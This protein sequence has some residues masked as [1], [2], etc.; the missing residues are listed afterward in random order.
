MSNRNTAGYAAG[1]EKRLSTRRNTAGVVS[2]RRQSNKKDSQQQ[3]QQPPQ[4]RVST[5]TRR[6]STPPPNVG[7]LSNVFQGKQKIESKV[8]AV[9]KNV[10]QIDSLGQS[11]DSKAE[12]IFLSGNVLRNLSGIERF[13]NLRVLSVGSNYLSTFES[14]EPLFNL[15]KLEVLSLI[16]NPVTQLP[17]Y[18]C[19]VILNCKHL[20]TLDNKEISQRER[21]IAVKVSTEESLQLKQMYINHSFII[22]SS[23]AS[24]TILLMASLPGWDVP[25]EVSPLMF[26]RA[27][28]ESWIAYNSFKSITNQLQRAV[29]RARL[30][31]MGASGSD[32]D[33]DSIVGWKSAYNSVSETQQGNIQ[34][35]FNKMVS[36]L[37]KVYGCTVST[38]NPLQIFSQHVETLLSKQQVGLLLPDVLALPAT[39]STALPPQQ[40]DPGTP[41][42]MIDNLKE[43]LT[44]RNEEAEK[45]H[46]RRMELSR[47][48]LPDPHCHRHGSRSG[49]V[50]PSDSLFADHQESVKRPIHRDHQLVGN[51]SDPSQHQRTE[52][53]T[54]E[55]FREELEKFKQDQEAAKHPHEEIER[56][57][58]L[59][60]AARGEL[61]M[62][63]INKALRN[64]LNNYQEALKRSSEKYRAKV[65]QFKTNES[66]LLQKLRSAEEAY[67]A[68]VAELDSAKSEVSYWKV[69][70]AEYQSELKN[71]KEN[72][73]PEPTNDV[74]W[75]QQAEEYFNELQ[76]LKLNQTATSVSSNQQPVTSDALLWKQRSE[77]LEVENKRLTLLQNAPGKIA[78][79][80][81]NWK[82]QCMEFKQENAQLKHQ[83][84][85]QQIKIVP[86]R[87]ANLTLLKEENEQLKYQIESLRQE[88]ESDLIDRTANK[89]LIQSLRSDCELWKGKASE[90]LDVIEKLRSAVELG[91]SVIADKL[92]G[93]VS[94]WKSKCD[95]QS[96]ELHILSQHLQDLQD[97]ISEDSEHSPAADF[98]IKKRNFAQFKLGI[99]AASQKR[100]A[101]DILQ[102]VQAKV[103]VS[104]ALKEWNRI[105]K[106]DSFTQF[107]S[108]MHCHHL[109]NRYYRKLLRAARSRT[110]STKVNKLAS[111][112]DTWMSSKERDDSSQQSTPTVRQKKVIP[113]Q[114][115][116]SDGELINQCSATTEDLQHPITVVPQ[117]MNKTKLQYLKGRYQRTISKKKEISCDHF[118]QDE[119]T[120]ETVGT[121]VLTRDEMKST[122]KSYSDWLKQ[123]HISTVKRQQQQQHDFRHQQLS[124]AMA[125]WRRQ[126]VIE[127]QNR[128]STT[129]SNQII[130]NKT[131]SLSRMAFSK[132]TSALKKR[133]L[134]SHLEE[135]FTSNRRSQLVKTHFG[136]WKSSCLSKLV[137]YKS[138]KQIIS[139]EVC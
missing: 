112:W 22:K 102:S 19:R 38:Q 1:H 109:V 122:E 10:S 96:H 95:D 52:Q 71:I 137:Q 138:E 73:S 35:E 59:L 106:V 54:T 11:Q 68:T 9:E 25:S 70:S 27:S 94:F 24:S 7:K 136:N 30:V 111:A 44:E 23:H 98:L 119:S 76:Q 57:G 123:Q 39:S 37:H 46:M 34:E 78:L 31:Q 100:F 82:Q 84:E 114:F 126:T 26:L 77:E 2:Q 49:S 51:H 117:K 127:R 113:D 103:R 20:V 91:P 43:H 128:F 53:E 55:L 89:R 40:A 101:C 121:K 29:R 5:P 60:E 92:Q 56:E 4:R 75:K 58:D 16:N 80:E 45:K 15:R 133:R 36:L 86:Q 131:S 118:S 129:L 48:H 28:L 135:R 62:Q 47:Q 13:V 81:S 8:S 79:Q 63:E 139:E 69:K 87:E 97:D 124:K 116:A 115:I 93:D 42:E 120:S 14:L 83:L 107:S 67:S 108:K 12:I 88:E 104:S 132:W 17:Y 18:R 66:E 134:L 21:Q 90:H 125:A 74:L 65:Q 61:M 41:I 105:A 6:T 50:S 32:K 72:P 99:R 3:Q 85:L 110:I 130:K 64:E 33:I